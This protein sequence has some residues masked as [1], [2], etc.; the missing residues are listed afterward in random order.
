[1]AINISGGFDNLFDDFNKMASDD[2]MDAI[3]SD[4]AA[5]ARENNMSSVDDIELN[6]EGATSDI[7]LDEQT[8]RARANKI[9]AD[10]E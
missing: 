5:T 6:I 9:L 8:I 4:L 7:P 3:A 2:A 10:D 1:M